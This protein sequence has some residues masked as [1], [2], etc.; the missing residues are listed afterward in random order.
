LRIEL[1]RVQRRR[2]LDAAARHPRMLRL[3]AQHR[4]S[5][6]FLGRLA[7]RDVV[8][9]D[10]PSR[11][12]RLRPR[13]AFEQAAVDQQPVDAPADQASFTVLTAASLPSASNTLATM[14]LRSRP[15]S[16]YIAFGES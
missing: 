6:N 11:D 3:G 13:A 5:R 7:D 15:A 8:G 2:E 4:V 16:A 10:E 1:E 14:P 9:G 12:R